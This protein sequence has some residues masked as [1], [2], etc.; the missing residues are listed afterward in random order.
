[1]SYAIAWTLA[2]LAA[3]TLAFIAYRLYRKRGL[4]AP[5]L[6][7]IVI[8]WSVFPWRFDGEHY[9]PLF[10]VFVFRNLFEREL[11]TAN[12]TMTGILGTTLIMLGFLIFHIVRTARRRRHF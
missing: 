7:T 10:V 3:G 12:V 4:W 6:S 5:F 8:F 11:G 2:V 1:M 9:A